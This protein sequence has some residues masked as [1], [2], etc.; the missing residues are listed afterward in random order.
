M[1]AFLLVHAMPERIEN[2]HLVTMTP[3]VSPRAI[4][5]QLPLTEG[6]AGIVLHTRRAICDILHGHDRQRLL[7]VVGPCSL[8]DVEAAYEYAERL[9]PVID[10]TREQ[11]VIVMRTYFEKPRTT[12]GWKGLINDP[13]L[14]GSCD[15]PTGLA[16]ARE[17]LLRINHIGV[18][19]ASE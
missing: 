14:D 10:A 18:P 1:P 19:C 2:S 12:V 4:K 5:A 17:I 7:V 13:H 15:I 9:K 8:H 16:L 11:L 6:A 3:L